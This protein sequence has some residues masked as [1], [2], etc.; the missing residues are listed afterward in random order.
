MLYSVYY[1]L[2]DIIDTVVL[3]CL[4]LTYTILIL[5][6]GTLHWAWTKNAGPCD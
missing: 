2:S 3:Q 1:S 6:D 5:V 4:Y